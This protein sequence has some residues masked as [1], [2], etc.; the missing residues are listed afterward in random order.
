MRDPPSRT[1]RSRP[2]S[3]ARL[4]M[5][6]GSARSRWSCARIASMI[7]YRRIRYWSATH[8][9]SIRE[10]G[11]ER[12]SVRVSSGFTSG[13]DARGTGPAVRAVLQEIGEGNVEGPEVGSRLAEVR[14]QGA[15]PEVHGLGSPCPRK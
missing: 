3:F 10:I 6:A 4:A 15:T 9:T 2:R 12:I 13:G 1:W 14:A 8:D 5:N 11:Y 7:A